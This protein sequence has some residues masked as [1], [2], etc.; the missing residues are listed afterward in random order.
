LAL[1][2]HGDIRVDSGFNCRIPVHDSRARNCPCEHPSHLCR[3]ACGGAGSWDIGR[4]IVEKQRLLGWGEA[5]IEQVA[6]DLQSAF[7]GTTGFSP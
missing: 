7:P 6:R 4:G 5:V 3:A 2:F 1:L